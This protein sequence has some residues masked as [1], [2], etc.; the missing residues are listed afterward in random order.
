MWRQDMENIPP[1]QLNLIFPVA[2][3]E[4]LEDLL[5]NTSTVTET[6]S[7]SEQDSW[8]SLT[9]EVSSDEW[10]SD[11]AGL[12]SEEEDSLEGG[13]G[14]GKGKGNSPPAEQLEGGRIWSL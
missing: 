10:S 5:E 7:S 6:P 3:P 14:K 8:D 1:N 12:S 9:V 2:P 4:N 13:R 11:S